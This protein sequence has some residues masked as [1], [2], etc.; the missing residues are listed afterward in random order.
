MEQ[1]SRGWISTGM[2][3]AAFGLV[4]LEV[5]ATRVIGYAVGNGDVAIT[6]ALAVLGVG[7]AGSLLSR[8]RSSRGATAS[9]A[10]SLAALFT[11][12]AAVTTL[13]LF[14]LARVLKAGENELVSKVL[15]DSTLD[16]FI[17][18]TVR[19][20]AHALYVLGAAMAF[21]YG[22]Y[23]G[24]IAV[25]FRDC[26]EGRVNRLY[27][28]DLGGGSLGA[29]G[30]IALLETGGFAPPFG[31]AVA[32]PLASA[33]CLLMAARRPR[34]AA[35]A[36]ALGAVALVVALSPLHDWFDPPPHPA[37]AARTLPGGQYARQ[38]AREIW[39]TWTSYGRIGA[40][41]LRDTADDPHPRTIMVHGRGEG[42]ARVPVFPPEQPM[43][44]ASR[45][46]TAACAPG[47]V[48]VL[49]AGAGFDM[50]NIDTDLGGRPSEI[51]GVELVPQVFGWPTSQPGSEL[52]RYLAR[53]GRK[54]V[55][56][57]ARTFLA[58]DRSKYDCVLISWWGHT[59]SYYTGAAAASFEHVYSKEA[60]ASILDHLTPGGQLTILNGN[61]V[62]AM[63]T[64]RELFAERGDSTPAA[65]FAVVARDGDVRTWD[66]PENHSV[67]MVKPAGVSAADV[68]HISSLLSG[69]Y[70][71]FYAPGIA[72]TAA[73]K[74]FVVA[75]TAAE[76]G[77]AVAALLPRAVSLEPTNDD[78]PY[79][80]SVVPRDAFLHSWF[81]S[82][83]RPAGLNRHVVNQLDQ[84]RRRAVFPLV[85]L[86]VAAAVVLAP[87]ALGRGRA[88]VFLPRAAWVHLAYFAGIG[89][90]F[91]WLEVGLIQ[92][93]RM[94][95]GH[96]GYALGIVLSSIMLF[97]GLGSLLS[98]RTFASGRVGARGVA[99][100]AALLAL[101][102]AAGLDALVPH[103]MA[104]PRAVGFAL[105]F[106][107]PAPLALVLGHLLPR[108]VAA[109]PP[110]HAHLIPWALGVNAAA[111][112]VATAMSSPLSYALGF[113]SLLLLGA[114]A[115]AV[116]A[117]LPA[118]PPAGRA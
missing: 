20:Q 41:E 91:M 4:L 58:R 107:L 103:A 57:E 95:V 111:G 118:R 106:A 53:P 84:W 62:R 78:W 51:V 68:E 69:P 11:G 59:I 25:L 39:H 17:E 54:L 63:L 73:N 98:E 117:A 47:R 76:P 89:A 109:I 100:F 93:L 2:F 96:P 52:A 8:P 21:S 29:L 104:A 18:I 94:I 75:A 114:V 43:E 48:L 19:Q 42:H 79:F 3:L 35:G 22:L 24:A 115:Y 82:S 65:R 113:R 72:P 49:L 88:G 32:A 6:I 116:V 13:G 1:A 23:G 70:K 97:T 83:H 33:A 80:R 66:D 77:A 5:T 15:G 74:P 67:L 86:L 112:T 90:G 34:A 27:A 56:A 50:V 28:A 60:F 44:I 92:K 108:G 37:S 7:A 30:A 85:L 12:C 71:V 102:Y 31:A 105:A 61:K 55:A 46:A 64:L 45:L 10:C 14:A 16:A 99:L 87:V 110:E 36:A 40:M 9:R 38:H 81:W 101:A 26:G